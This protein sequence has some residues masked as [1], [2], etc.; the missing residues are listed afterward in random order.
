MTVLT[1][2]G[3]ATTFGHLHNFVHQVLGPLGEVIPLKHANGPVPNNL[4]SSAHSLS[5]N[6]GALRPTVQT[7]N[8]TKK[9]S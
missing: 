9:F 4:L 3:D 6:L 1:N 7:L 2:D 5:K 8:R